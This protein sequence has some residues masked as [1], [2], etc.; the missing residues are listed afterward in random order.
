MAE[1]A[2]SRKAKPNSSKAN[3]SSRPTAGHNSGAVPDSVYLSWLG[4]IEIAKNALDKVT[5]LRRQKN[6]EYRAILKAAKD[7]G[8]NVDAILEARELHAKDHTIV[9][10]DYRDI[11]RVLRLIRSPLAVQLEL[12]ADQALSSPANARLAG[13]HAGQNGESADN[14]AHKPGTEEHVQWRQGWGEGQASIA[15]KM[16]SGQHADA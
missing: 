5:D 12:F 11:G 8:C 3:G 6:G 9:V 14:N 4:K 10:V 1:R 7:D 16:G 13:F 15:A 2:R